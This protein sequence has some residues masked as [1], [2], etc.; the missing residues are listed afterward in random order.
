MESRRISSPSAES[1]VNGVDSRVVETGSSVVSGQHSAFVNLRAGIPQGSVLGPVLFLIYINDLPACMNNIETVLFADDSTFSKTVQTMDQCATTF[2]STLSSAELWF[3]SNC[4]FMN[5]SKTEK[6]IFSLRPLVNFENPASVR[7][8]GVLLQPNLCWDSHMENIAKKMNSNIF[9]LRNLAESVSRNVL[10]I[11][12][13]GL[14][15]P[16][17]TYAVMAWGHSAIKDRAFSLQRKAIR[18]VYGLGYRDSCDHAFRDLGILT[19]PCLFI[20]EC[21][22]YIKKNE[23]EFPRQ[24]NM[25]SHNTRH[26]N[27]IRPE[28]TRLT[29]N[30]CGTKYWCAKF[31]NKLPGLI[32]DSPLPTFKKHV[33]EFL[34]NKTFYN[35]DEFLNDSMADFNV[36]L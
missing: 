16:H 30:Q 24:R 36:R 34:I 9:L 10:K 21:L 8:L 11:A 13:F 3:N 18:V 2:D 20:Y 28:F 6:I 26:T 23:N 32:K 15:H 33:K 4:L 35:F 29:K 17:L 22:I 12:Y 27:D 19:F 1:A 14:I 25:H 5:R 7:F 31:Y